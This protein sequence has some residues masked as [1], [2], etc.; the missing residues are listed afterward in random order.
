V[1]VI[2]YLVSILRYGKPTGDHN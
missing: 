1:P 2:Q